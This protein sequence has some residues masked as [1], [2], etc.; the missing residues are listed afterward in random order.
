MIEQP[1]ILRPQL[2]RRFPLLAAIIL[3]VSVFS[4]SIYAN[5]SYSVTNKRGFEYFPPFEADRNA[6]W[7][8]HLGAE[9]F[10]IAWSLNT[11]QGY[12]NP[13][14]NLESGPTAW[15]PPIYPGILAGLLWAFDGDRD[16]VMMVV[17][18]LQVFVLIGTGLLV[19]ALIRQ[20]SPRFGTGV[21]L[22]VFLFFVVLC[23]FSLWFQFTHD[24]WLVL[25]ALEL[26]IAGLCWLQPFRRWQS[27]ALW[28]LFGGL[29]SLI[30]PLLGLTWGV[31][32]TL[33]GADRR[34]W[35]LLA[36]SMLTAAVTLAPWIVR[37]YV[38]F[39]RFIPVKPN[40]AFE[41]YQSQCLQ[42][43]GLIQRSTF[44]RRHPNSPKA[45]AERQE[46]KA[47]GETGYLDRKLDQF[48]QS[49]Q[50]DPDSFIERVGDR[51][52]GATLWYEPVDRADK[53]KR[54]W[55]LRLYRLAHPLPFLAL[56]VLLATA[57]WK[58]LQWAQWVVLGVYVIYLL[59]YIGIS[60]YDRYAAPLLAVKALMVIWAADSL[61]CLWSAARQRRRVVAP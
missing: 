15:M 20:T 49:V 3:V 35:T 41:L 10:H 32:S 5:Y 51:F 45:I 12:A 46:Y 23:D 18:L 57:L 50:R 21:A 54:P 34:K 37:N 16:R 8:H 22:G 48:W 40:L 39:G 25:L 9:Y 60:Y 47:L 43:D 7:N 26:L 44:E 33:V 27:A 36:L 1:S 6:N 61:L 53:T 59:P 55:V 19:V 29:C 13:F 11:G 56:V 24:C 31:F 30:N 17:I 2:V 28:G 58:P 42:S 14:N 4:C 52:L 38:V